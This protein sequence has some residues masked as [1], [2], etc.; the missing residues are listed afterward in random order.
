MK[1]WPWYTRSVTEPAVLAWE[2][3]SSPALIALAAVYFA[4]VS[5]LLLDPSD[6][7]YTIA[8]VLAVACWLAFFGDYLVRLVK[9]HDRAWFIRTRWPDLLFLVLTLVPHLHFLRML[10]LL[11]VLHGRA[12]GSLRDRVVV[13]ILG[14]T[15]MLIWSASVL[16]LLVER[17]AAGATI[18]SIGTALWWAITTIT[19]VGYGDVFPVTAVGR[20]IAGVVLLA[21]IALVGAVTAAFASWLLDRAG[22]TDPAGDGMQDPVDERDLVV[23]LLAEVRQ[24]RAEVQALSRSDESADGVPLGRS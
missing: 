8:V 9:A 16:E 10:P 7:Q 3:R 18:T 17:H 14:A 23:E 13:Y 20:V 5:W 22:Q 6:T 4:V 2:R 1:A 21:G 12:W 15:T 19:T 24:L 11:L